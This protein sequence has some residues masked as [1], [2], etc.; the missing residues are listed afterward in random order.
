[1]VLKNADPKQNPMTTIVG[2]ILLAI[3]IGLI[4]L[5]NFY[6]TKEDPN[7][8]WD[9]IIAGIGLALI[10]VPDTVFGFLKRKSDT[11]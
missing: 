6:E 2:A 9:A 3:G 4:V 1:M 7:Y 5:P 10:F 8:T 11:L